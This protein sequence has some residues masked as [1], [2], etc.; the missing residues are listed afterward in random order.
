MKKPAFTKEESLAL[1]AVAVLLIIM[2]HSISGTSVY[3]GFSL[4]FF[5]FSESQVN[6]IGAYCKI[7]VGIFAFI[8]GYGITKKYQ[9]SEKTIS[10]RAISQ[11]TS[12]IKAFLPVFI[13]CVLITAAIDGRPFTVYAGKFPSQGLMNL[14]LDSLGIAKLMGTPNLDGSWWYLSAMTVFCFAAPLF[15]VAIHRTG[16]LVPIFALIAFPRLTGMGYLPGAD[17]LPFYFLMAVLLGVIF[18]EY[19][20]FERIDMIQPIKWGEPCQISCCGWLLPLCYF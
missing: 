12:S 15:Q 6:H 10:Q 2:H 9:D 1:K 17:V 16:W 8:S 11:Y 19:D 5:P 3:W 18:A 7:C 20:L 4:N 14:L 13:I